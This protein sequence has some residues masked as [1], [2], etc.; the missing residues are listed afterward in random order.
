MRILIVIDGDFHWNAEQA[1]IFKSSLRPRFLIQ[2][3]ES[4]VAP[5]P[6]TFTAA[7]DDAEHC[8][9]LEILEK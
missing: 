9:M 4:F 1:Q 2:D 7:K 3:Q 6:C 8:L 5:H